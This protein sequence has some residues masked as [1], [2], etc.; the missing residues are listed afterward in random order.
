MFALLWLLSLR[1]VDVRG[2]AQA[3]GL[4]AIWI[5][6]TVVPPFEGERA[7]AY[8]LFQQGVLLAVATFCLLR[9]S[10]PEAAEPRAAGSSRG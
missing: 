2:G 7:V 5:L 4:A 6:L 1:A 8:S 9:T 10:G 3:F